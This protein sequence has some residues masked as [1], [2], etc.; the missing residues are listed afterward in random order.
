MC[1]LWKLIMLSHVEYGDDDDYDEVYVIV[2]DCA[3]LWR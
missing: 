2:N 3:D 1:C